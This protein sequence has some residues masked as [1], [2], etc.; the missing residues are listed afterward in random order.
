MV[1]CPS[2]YSLRSQAQTSRFTVLTPDELRRRFALGASADEFKAALP[3]GGARLA[4]LESMVDADPSV[5]AF[6]QI[7]AEL[8]MLAIAEGWC[9]D[10]QDGLAVL[11]RLASSQPRVRLRIF[12]RDQN[13]DLMAAYRKDGQFDSIPVFVFLGPD[14]AEIGR[15]VER[16]DKVTSLLLRHRSELAERSP[17][18]APPD[19][20]LRSFSEGVRERLRA[21]LER[22]RERDR[23]KA[24]AIIATALE[25]LAVRAA[26]GAV[27]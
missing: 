16:P 2:V 17:E 18:F 10:S 4:T 1:L 20:P 19:A 24:N 6:A 27:A 14:F 25:A 15:Y 11:L 26:D 12:A 5:S 9:R 3:D 13:P 21:D 8:N 22:L 23:P 7:G